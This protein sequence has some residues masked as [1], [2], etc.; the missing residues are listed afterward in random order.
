MDAGIAA[1]WFGGMLFAAVFV[2]GAA[3]FF[4]AF[5]F[6]SIRT[7][8]SRFGHPGGLDGSSAGNPRTP[9]L[10]HPLLDETAANSGQQQASGAMATGRRAASPPSSSSAFGAATATS[11]SSSS[12]SSAAVIADLQTQL[13]TY[14]A[15]VFASSTGGGV[16]AAGSSTG[17]RLGA[18]AVASAAAGGAAAG[19]GAGVWDQREFL[20]RCS[21]VVSKTAIALDECVCDAFTAAPAGAGGD[22]NTRMAKAMRLLWSGASAAVEGHVA[23]QK[24]ALLQVSTSVSMATGI[25]GAAMSSSTS[26]SS[27]M[28]QSLESSTLFTVYYRS[29]LE[30]MFCDSAVWS[31]MATQ[32]LQSWCNALITNNLCTADGAQGIMAD[33]ASCGLLSAIQIHLQLAM[34]PAITGSSLRWALSQPAS[35]L[36]LERCAHDIATQQSFSLDGRP[37]QPGSQVFIVGPSLFSSSSTAT[38]SALAVSPEVSAIRQSCKTLVIPAV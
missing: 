3:L 10:D 29:V 12:S 27:A 33:A 26:P 5:A 32:V 2:A 20:R 4:P 14:K 34:W 15:M 7:L 28:R 36:T 1:G 19:A 22:V 6:T 23:A 21:E 25:G 17:G 37:V 35:A 18:S 16:G 24:Q 38:T 31:A 13:D 30:L 11:S 8:H 9:L